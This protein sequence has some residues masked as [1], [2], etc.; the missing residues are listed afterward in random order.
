MIE[1]LAR[2]VALAVA[3]LGIL[4]VIG[5]GWLPGGKPDADAYWL[6]AMRLREGAPLYAAAYAS[7]IDIYRYAPWFAYL[8]IPF[9]YL[10]Q[11][12]AYVLWRAILF[13]AAVATVWP[14]VRRPSPAG[15]VL[16]L[17][18]FGL[19][20]SNLASA[21]VTVL[22]LGALSL[23]LPSPRAGPV[24][25]AL[26]AS[27]KGYP[28]LLGAGYLA[29]RRWR[30]IVV[31]MVLTAILWAHA[32]LFDL[33][34]YPTAFTGAELSLYRIVPGMWPVG[35]LALFG[36]LGWMAI[37]RSRWTWLMA[38][39][40]TMLLVPGVWLTDIGYA[41]VA[42]SVLLDRLPGRNAVRA[43]G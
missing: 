35:V 24:V 9:T 6:A 43:D 18:V 40:L 28:L 14:I 4:L 30:E 26:S 36:I 29:E 8:W 17:L 3:F 2:L 19:L 7:D 22:M 34:N 38:A 41:A 1:R 31:A 32:L 16:S 20:L 12:I 5:A 13:A 25:L 42:A 15:L 10:P 39:V 37:R 21:N 33:A 27:L 23:A 11:G